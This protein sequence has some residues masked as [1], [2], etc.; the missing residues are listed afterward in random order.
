MQ[1]PSCSSHS[2]LSLSLL[3][4]C[5]S[6]SWMLVSCAVL[7]LASWVAGCMTALVHTAASGPLSSAAVLA[8]S[9]NQHVSP[10]QP[11]VLLCATAASLR[12]ALHLIP[13]HNSHTVM[14]GQR[15]NCCMRITGVPE[16]SV[17]AELPE[18]HGH[19]HHLSCMAMA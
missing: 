12:L 3:G 8:H 13:C 6:A 5:F 7:V 18:L 4:G 9:S 15:P 19:G 14:T 1:A 11:D 2:W 16:L 17:A 10:Q